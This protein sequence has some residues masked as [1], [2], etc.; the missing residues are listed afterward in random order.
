MAAIQKELELADAF[1]AVIP[2]SGQG[3]ANNVLFEMGAA[4]ALKKPI[5]AVIPGR[6]NNTHRR[7]LPS[8]LMGMLVLDAEKKSVE[9]VAGTLASTLLAA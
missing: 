7:E 5:L 4:R 9:A 3:T 2:E 8:D 1:L 6:E